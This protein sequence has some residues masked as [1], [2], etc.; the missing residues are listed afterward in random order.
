MSIFT[1]ADLH[2]SINETT[3]KS[4]EVFGKRWKNY[5]E[6]LKQNWE[7]LVA[8][9]DTVIIPGDI[10]WAMN[11]KEAKEDMLFL[12]SLPGQKIIGKGNHDFWWATLSKTHA[13]FEENDI[14]S[15]QCLYNNAFWVEDLIVCG[16][17][18]WFNDESLNGIPEN[19]DY[20][21]II[22]REVM[23]LKLSLEEGKQFPK[24]LERVVFLHFPPVFREF[25]CEEIL[26]ILKVYNIKRCFYGHIHG[27]YDH[28][29]TF[30][31]DGIT[32][33]L[34]SADHL[35][36]IPRKISSNL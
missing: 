7:A 30:M 33:S 36:F 22:N 6:K 4:M 35:N 34:I 26:E 14:H 18:G 1:I 28:P 21:K 27:C 24:E 3:N 11:L 19:T 29:G 23:R 9:S 8:P 32:Y 2:L 5:V 20:N 12:D 31:D 25:R 17:R 16:S 13:F 15:I 10:S